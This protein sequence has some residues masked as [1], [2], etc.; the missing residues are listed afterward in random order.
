M[1]SYLKAEVLKAFAITSSAFYWPFFFADG[2]P[3]DY[4]HDSSREND[5]FVVDEISG[6]T[7]DY[8]AYNFIQEDNFTQV[9]VDWASKLIEVRAIDQRGKQLAHSTLKLA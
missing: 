4:V 6:V 9:D 5:T 7:M 8:V 1:A 2:E 3:S